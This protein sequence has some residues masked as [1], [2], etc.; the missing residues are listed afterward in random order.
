MTRIV[1]QHPDNKGGDQVHSQVVPTQPSG[2]VI[3]AVL[4]PDPL[5]MDIT[6]DPQ[7]EEVIKVSESLV[8]FMLCILQ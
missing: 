7:D 1:L 5:C 8:L 3:P 4:S 2:E 6:G